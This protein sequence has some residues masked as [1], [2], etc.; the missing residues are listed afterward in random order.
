MISPA[1]IPAF[2]RRGASNTDLTGNASDQ[3]I[4]SAVSNANGAIIRT[5]FLIAG[6]GNF[7]YLKIGGVNVFAA[8]NVGFFNYF[9]PGIFVPPGLAIAFF[10]P[11]NG[12]GNVSM[13]Y[14]L[15]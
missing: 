14:D 2:Q 9:G 13:T 4:V 1:S 12:A 7:C 11:V 15:L 8:N 10:S 3:V 6:A 5:L